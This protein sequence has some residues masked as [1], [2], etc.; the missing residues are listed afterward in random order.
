MAEALRDFWY[1]AGA[2]GASLGATAQARIAFPPCASSSTASSP[3]VGPHACSQMSEFLGDELRMTAR[4]PA[5]DQGGDAAPP[6][7]LLLL[8][9]YQSAG[10]SDFFGDDD[11]FA[12]LEARLGAEGGGDFGAAAA[13]ASEEEILGGDAQVGAGGDRRHEGVPVLERRAHGGRADGRRDVPAVPR[14]GAEPIYQAF[15]EQVEELAL[16]DEKTLATV[17]LDHPRL[18]AV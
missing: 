12:A 10:F 5:A 6:A 4:H 9:S 14:R 8:K 18:C 17:L 15:W 13:R 11:P 7:P 3:A 16:T 2:M 1:V